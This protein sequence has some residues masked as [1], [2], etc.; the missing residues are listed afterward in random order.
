MPRYARLFVP[1]IP[2]HIVQRGHDRDVVFIEQG[3]RQYY[4]DNLVEAKDR[5][6]I[7]VHAFCLMTNH[8]HLLISPGPEAAT[9]SEFMRVLAARQT[10]HINKRGNRTGTLWEGRFKASLVDT[11]SYVLACYRYIELNPVRAGMVRHP[12][13]YEWSSYRHNAGIEQSDW[14]NEHPEMCALSSELRTRQMAYAKFVG[15]DIRDEECGVIRT[16]LQRNQLT[17][18]DRFRK[19]LERRTGRRL[20]TAGPGRPVK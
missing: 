4:L 14:L 5:Y 11:S 3:D 18:N 1:G 15:A 17:G 19:E 9:I 20:S 8:V 13:E 12:A 16:A 10:R 2:A 6:D 7:D